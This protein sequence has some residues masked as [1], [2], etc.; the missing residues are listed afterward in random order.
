MKKCIIGIP[1]YKDNLNDTERISL[2]RISQ[3]FKNEEIV[4]IAPISLKFDFTEILSEYQ[5]LHFPNHFFSN[6]RSYSQLLLSTTFYESFKNYEYLLICQLDVFVFSNRLNEFCN[7]NYD[8]IGAPMYFPFGAN[9]GNGG[10]SLRKINSCI[11]M[12]KMRDK[13]YFNNPWQLSLEMMEDQF[14]S[15]C[16]ARE[17]FNFQVPSVDLA[18]GFA[19]DACFEMKGQEIVPFAI[20]NFN[21]ISF[22]WKQKISSLGFDLPEATINEIQ[23]FDKNVEQMKNCFWEY[24]LYQS[25]NLSKIKASFNQVFPLKV[26]ALW[27]YGTN[28][29]RCQNLFNL[30]GIK[31]SCIYDNGFTYTKTV[32]GVLYTNFQQFGLVKD[33]PLLITTV[34]YE[35]E[36]SGKLIDL[37]LKKNQDFFLFSEIEKE[38]LS[39]YFDKQ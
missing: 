36:I 1:I 11:R 32:D 2:Q 6:R 25:P 34:D 8:Y 33:L 31:I 22:F 35:D 17:E 20:H 21:F 23:V 15:Y 39:K 10:F 5:V 26:V 27:G 30:A 29:N 28:G 4:F 7:L 24:K 19:L 38:V 37:G 18:R 13:I 14:F 12:L 3:C 9:V 16:G